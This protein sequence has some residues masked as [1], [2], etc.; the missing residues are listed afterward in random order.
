MQPKAD[1]VHKEEE[2]TL[3]NNITLVR[4]IHT[5]SVYFVIIVGQSHGC[6]LCSCD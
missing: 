2:E 4:Q 1:M 6:A 5:I 3:F